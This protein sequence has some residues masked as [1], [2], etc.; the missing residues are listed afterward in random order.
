MPAVEIDEARRWSCQDGTGQLGLE[1]DVV[2]SESPEFKAT[3]TAIPV[4]SGATISDHVNCAPLTLNIEGIVTH[5]PV[6]ILGGLQSLTPGNPVAAA[7]RFLTNVWMAREPFTFVGGLQVYRNMVI[8]SYV[9]RKNSSNVHALEFTATMQQ[10]PI[11]FSD[12]TPVVNF[13]TPAEGA[14]EKVNRGMVQPEPASPKLEAE[15]SALYQ[16]VIG[17]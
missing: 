8:T 16:R 4:E 9:P 7:H 10:I 14:A 12:T 11:V 17:R 3:A 1:L 13:K 6:A 15:S 5:T 2:V